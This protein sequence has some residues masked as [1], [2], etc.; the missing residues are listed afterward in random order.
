MNE[1]AVIVTLVEGNLVKY[2]YCYTSGRAP[3]KSLFESV[4]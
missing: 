3:D 4:A 1:L 2:V